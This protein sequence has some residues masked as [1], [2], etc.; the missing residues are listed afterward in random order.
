[1]LCELL[2]LLTAS[3]LKGMLLLTLLLLEVLRSESSYVL[4]HLRR[5][6]ETILVTLVEVI[7]AEVLGTLG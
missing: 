1:L 6:V 2:N 7:K 3:Y 4:R 5:K